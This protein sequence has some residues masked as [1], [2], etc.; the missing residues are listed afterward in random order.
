MTGTVCLSSSKGVFIVPPG[1]PFRVTWVG[2]L[3]HDLIWSAGLKHT[4][5]TALTPGGGVRVLYRAGWA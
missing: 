5:L 4:L 3:S 2:C 1:S